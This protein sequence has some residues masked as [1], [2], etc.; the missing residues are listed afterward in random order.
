M[1]RAEVGRVVG[2]LRIMVVGGGVC[3]VLAYLRLMFT[4]KKLETW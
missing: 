4:H 3:L 1:S 2:S